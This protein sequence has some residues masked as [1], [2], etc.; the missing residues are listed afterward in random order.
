M[1]IT[2]TVLG[3]ALAA[4]LLGHLAAQNPRPRLPSGVTTNAVPK[5]GIDAIITTDMNALTLPQLVQSLLGPGV[6]A[7]NIVLTGAPGASKVIVAM[8]PAAP[9]VP[10]S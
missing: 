9:S 6:V 2:T 1:N 5:A 10:I 4:T 3:T 7:S 8:L